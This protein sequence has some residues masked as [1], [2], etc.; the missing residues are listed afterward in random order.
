MDIY[1]QVYILDRGIVLFPWKAVGFKAENVRGPFETWEC[2]TIPPKVRGKLL[3]K[4]QTAHLFSVALG[5][6]VSS[7]SLRMQWGCHWEFSITIFWLSHIA[8]LSW[9]FFFFD[10]QYFFL[11]YF[12]FVLLLN[13]FYHLITFHCVIVTWSFASVT[14]LSLQMG[15]LSQCAEQVF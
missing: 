15:L 10:P 6:V 8:L 12:S 2:F 1:H 13:Y 5:S 11:N 3:C 14:H 9:L 4:H 7:N